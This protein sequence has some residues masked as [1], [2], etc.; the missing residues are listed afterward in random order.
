MGKSTISMAIFNCYVSSPEGIP[1]FK[2]VQKCWAPVSLL[3]MRLLQI[4]P[5]DFSSWARAHR[6]HHLEAPHQP[7]TLD[8]DATIHGFS[9][10]IFPWLMGVPMT[11][12]GFYMV[13]HMGFLCAKFMGGFPVTFQLSDFPFQFRNLISHQCVAG[14]GSPVWLILRMGRA[15]RMRGQALEKCVPRAPLCHAM[16]WGRELNVHLDIGLDLDRYR[17]KFG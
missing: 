11:Y 7:S 1:D 9:M 12:D 10:G 3:T 5:S 16:T 14:W 4:R 8:P 17:L 15:H 13:K 2:A 6:Y